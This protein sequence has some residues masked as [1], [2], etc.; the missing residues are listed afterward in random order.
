[1][2]NEKQKTSNREPL[3]SSA[4]L[5][6]A[7]SILS[8][9]A[10]AADIALLINK[11]N[12]EEEHAHDITL[13]RFRADLKDIDKYHRSEVKIELDHKDGLYLATTKEDIDEYFTYQ[14]EPDLSNYNY[15]FYTYTVMCHGYPEYNRAIAENNKLTV[16]TTWHAS[17]GLC[18][19]KDSVMAWAIPKTYSSIDQIEHNEII[20]DTDYDPHDITSYKPILYL[21]P[22]KETN[23]SV[24]Y[25]RSDLLTT[26]YPKY[27]DDWNVTASPDGTL[28]DKNDRKYYALYWEGI[29]KYKPDY[30]EGFYV[31]KAEVAAFLEEK[32]Q[33]IGLNY[34]EQNEFIMYW[35]PKFEE[36]EKSIV[37]F[38]LTDE[39]NEREPLEFSTKPDSLLRIRMYIKKVNEKPSNLTEQPLPTFERKGF[40]AVEWGGTIIE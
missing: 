3:S 37:Y 16:Q 1:M 25:V 21:Y 20:D 24:K 12:Y 38:S 4:K 36:N 33:K 7:L 22:E 13:E 14:S 29:D 18:A 8:I 30:S 17:N 2:A 31:E 15:L 28:T 5:I 27:E 10:I 19:P 32:L 40:T 34:K 9:V 26:T 35:L 11:K 23:L 6:L 39:L